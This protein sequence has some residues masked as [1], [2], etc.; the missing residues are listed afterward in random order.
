YLCVM[1][2]ILN[3]DFAS[4]Q[5]TNVNDETYLI[6]ALRKEKARFQE[7]KDRWELRQKEYESGITTLEL[8]NR[9]KQEFEVALVVYQQALLRVVFDQ[10]YIIVEEAVKYQAQ[11]GERKHVRLKLRNTTSGKLDY[12]KVLEQEGELLSEDLLLDRISNVFV[13]LINI[14]DNT[15]ISKP[16]EKRIPYILF[17]ESVEV[18]FELLRDVENVRISMVYVDKTSIK[19]VYL[20]KD[21]TANKVDITST[22]FSQEAELG[23]STTYNLRLERFSGEDDVYFLELVNLPRQITYNFVEQGSPSRI[24]SIKFSEGITAKNITLTLFMPER[25]DASVVTDQP[26]NFY[27]ISFSQDKRDELGDLRGRT[28][29][30]AEIQEISVG[31]ENLEIIPKGVGE[32][33]ILLDNM[34]FP[35]KQGE[36]LTIEAKVRNIG[37]RRLDNVQLEI[38]SPLKWDVTANPELI[39]SIDVG[40]EEDIEIIVSTSED[41]GIGDNTVT[42]KAQAMADNRNIESDDK[43]IRIHVEAE[44]NILGTFVLAAFLIAIVIG[45]VVLGRK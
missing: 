5:I 20:E 10:P 43:D 18:D 16:Y 37:S 41:P 33:D 36:V 12:Q 27:L 35:I 7:I 42:I 14:E 17:G 32:V 30:P 15:I 25:S 39:S 19:D 1:I 29:T 40:G 38:E 13:S 22:Q 6:L 31:F 8:Y 44:K 21:V 23:A 3:S 28:F 11:P 9:T 26:L 4:A 45:I 24:S 2:L 34:Y